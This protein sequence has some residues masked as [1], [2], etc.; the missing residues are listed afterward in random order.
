MAA[1]LAPVLH[2]YEV[3]SDAVNTMPCPLHIA[4]SLPAFATG[5][6]LTATVMLSLAEHEFAAVTVTLYVEVVG[7]VTLM[8]DVIPP[9]LHKKDVPPEAVS[10]ADCPWHIEISAPALTI[11]KLLTLTSTSSVALH[12][13]ALVTV[14]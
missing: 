7:G 3:P 11:G 14:T 6:G 8:E 2:W 13:T 5:K 10:V 1:V 9:V 4:W 12:P